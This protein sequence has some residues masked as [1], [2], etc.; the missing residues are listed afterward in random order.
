MWLVLICCVVLVI[1]AA[2]V[3]AAGNETVNTLPDSNAGTFRTNSRAFWQDELPSILRRYFPDGRVI[4]GG[5]HAATSTTCISDTFATEA[6]TSTN[7]TFS[8]GGNRVRARSDGTGGTAAVN[9]SLVGANCSNPGSDT[10]RL[11]ICAL[12]GNSTGNWERAAGSN[13]FVNAVDTTPT[14]PADCTP[15]LDATISNGTITAI[16]DIRPTTPSL[17]TSTRGAL[18]TPVPAIGI[19]GGIANVTDDAR[20]AWVYQGSAWSSLNSRAIDIRA[21]G[22]LCDDST[23]DTVAIQ[24]A[25]TR[26][27]T[28]EVTYQPTSSSTIGIKPRVIF[29]PYS[30]CRITAAI[31][32]GAYAHI[33]SPSNT[34][35]RQM[36]STADVFTFGSGYQVD[37]DGVSLVGGRTQILFENNNT[38]SAFLKVRNCE[39]HNNNLNFM[40]RI[41]PTAPATQMSTLA[42]FKD[43]KIFNPYQVMDTYADTYMEEVWVQTFHDATGSSTA[44]NMA[45]AAM[46][47]VR[48]P[49]HATKLYGVPELGT[50]VTA[51]ARKMNARWFDNRGSIICDRCRFG[52]EDSGMPIVYNYSGPVDV[53]PY[54]GEGAII[55]TNSQIA[56][57]ASGTAEPSSSLIH[58]VTAVPQRIVLRDNW[59]LI[60]DAESYITTDAGLNLTTYFNGF[61][62][63]IRWNFVIENNGSHVNIDP[64]GLIPT[65][66][67]RRM[68]SFWYRNQA[69]D[70]GF[71]S[72]AGSRGQNNIALSDQFQ[73]ADDAA[74]TISTS[75]VG[76]SGILMILGQNA[77]YNAVFGFRR[78]GGSEQLQTLVLGTGVTNETTTDLTTG[79]A[80]GTDGSVNVSVNG[81]GSGAIKVKNRTGG[82]LDMRI[83][84]FSPQG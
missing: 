45:D 80:N 27:Q 7:S 44:P 16:T 84:V 6:I 83:I 14:A 20:G 76:S 22:A 78:A 50:G 2:H 26:A 34:V 73:L 21:F 17:I 71:A 5:L 9:Y 65:E 67:Q 81:A 46:F 51:P 75:S 49:F 13:Y 37:I 8:V 3:F 36:T 61:G 62:S 40:I 72:M 10:A 43:C 59:G 29:P 32:W 60:N 33:Y 31:A 28:L 39:L 12:T 63:N 69:G 38:N 55:I 11:A 47:V 82:T 57:G 25:A 1:G 58:F 41:V 68:S 70:T 19:T 24:A 53:Y 77:I 56:H 48:A 15:L 30:V 66:I 35:I 54:T 64:L 42:T 18:P 52:G 79:T 74:T 23:D 4:S